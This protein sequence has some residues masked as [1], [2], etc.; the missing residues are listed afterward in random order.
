MKVKN[1][2]LF[3]N[4]SQY[5]FSGNYYDFHNDFMCTEILFNAETLI[6]TFKKIVKDFVVSIQFNDVSLVY[7]NFDLNKKIEPLTIDLIYRGRY[8]KNKKLIE[9]ENNKGFIYTEFYEGQK[10]EFW[11]SSVELKE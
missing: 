6:F 3:K 2:E 8:E 1:I 5:D 11:S 9:F 10:I 4:L 7:S